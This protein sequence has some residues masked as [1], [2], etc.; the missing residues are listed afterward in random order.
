MEK[1]GRLFQWHGHVK[2]MDG[3][4]L[5]RRKIEL[6]FKGKEKEGLST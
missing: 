2:N 3:T 4:R 5:G 1:E 6:K